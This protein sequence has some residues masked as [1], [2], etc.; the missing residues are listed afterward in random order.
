MRFVVISLGSAG[1]R[2]VR[3][4]RAVDPTAE[5][6]VW[7]RGGRDL[8]DLAGIVTTVFTDDRSLDTWRPA[9]AILANPAPFHAKVARAC[10]DRGIHLFIEKPLATGLEGL[11]DLLDTCHRRGVTLMV[12]YCLRFHPALRALRQA[13]QDGRLGRILAL[14]AEVGQYLP[15]WRPGADYRDTVSAR[16]D[17]GGGALWELSHEIDYAR[18]LAGEVRAVRAWAGGVS[19]LKLAVEDTAEI[20]LE[21]D[22][23]AIGSVHLDMVQRTPHRRC[24][25]IGTDATAEWDGPAQQVHLLTP[26]VAP[27]TLWQGPYDANRMYV[28]ELRHFLA[29]IKTGEAP[30][31]SGEDGRRVVEIVLAAKKAAAA[32]GVTV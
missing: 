16:V 17:L 21:F 1:K 22:S 23:G 14:R 5:I 26:G 20:V 8:G 13:V 30:L 11:P 24:R 25:I 12:G 27:E 15:D 10:A 31:V 7:R 9:A 18:W 6:A 19:D 32:P 3:N 4:L 2:H 29:C 28:D